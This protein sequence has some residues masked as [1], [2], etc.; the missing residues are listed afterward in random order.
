MK[1]PNENRNFTMSS[2]NK[3]IQFSG[4]FEIEKTRASI[5]AFLEGK[6]YDLSEKDLTQ[7]NQAP[8][9]EL[10]VFVDGMR[11]RDDNF[12][13]WISFKLK[14]SGIDVEVMEN[15]VKKIKTKGD[16]QMIISGYLE[17]DPFNK[18]PKGGFNKFLFNLYNKFHMGHMWS[19]ALIELVTDKSQV[20]KLFRSQIGSKV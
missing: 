7:N 1:K 13:F 11:I 10:T 15:G 9:R 14:M 16:A 18:E 4:I 8:N 19:D 17:Q 2:K 6:N 12:A 5:M 3:H 20:E